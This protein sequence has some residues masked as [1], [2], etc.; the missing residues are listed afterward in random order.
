MLEI[1]PIKMR[2]ASS[3]VD[4]LRS[5]ILPDS[6][7]FT[8]RCVAEK[9]PYHF[10]CCSIDL[11]HDKDGKPIPE[12]MKYCQAFD[13][14]THKCS[15]YENRPDFCRM[16]VCE[17]QQLE[18]TFVSVEASV[19]SKQDR[20]FVWTKLK[21]RFEER[22]DIHFV[23]TKG[24]PV[25]SIVRDFADKHRRVVKVIDVTWYGYGKID[26]RKRNVD[27]V[28]AADFGLLFHVGKSAD[29]KDLQRKFDVLK[30][31]YVTFSRRN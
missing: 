25:E 10:V 3:T 6:G 26:W 12:T 29:I 8:P 11:K 24:S 1:N 15:I 22:I 9:C 17:V 23:V 20:E 7:A 5:V 19:G 4:L 30:K 28:E 21:E 13:K 27:I 16:W 31:R 14:D 18:P 2:G